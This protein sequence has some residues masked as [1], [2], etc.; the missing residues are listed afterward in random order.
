[1]PVLRLKSLY[2]FSSNL[3]SAMRGSSNWAI[4]VGKNVTA[5]AEYDTHVNFTI[6]AGHTNAAM[7]YNSDNLYKLVSEKFNFDYE[8]FPVSKDAQDDKIRIWIN[9]G[10]MPD[11]VTWRNFNY[12]EYVSYAQQGLIAPLPDGW[13][14]TYPNLYGM[15][16][17]SGIYDQMIVDGAIWPL[18]TY[19]ELVELESSIVRRQT[20]Y[21][22]TVQLN[23]A[24]KARDKAMGVI[25]NIITAHKTNTIEAKR[26]AALALDA[27]AVS[28][29]VKGNNG[30][31][32]VSVGEKKVA[33]GELNAAT[34]ISNLNMR[35]SYSIPY[36]AV[37]LIEENAEVV[38]NRAR[39]Q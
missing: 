11:S 10:T 37:S 30:V 33:E 22:S 4:A 14:E 31:Y 28:A 29:P 25:L 7:D 9:G 5:L 32:V 34:E 1:M 26:T 19:G 27:N 16:K 13:E 35:T 18:P 12:Q 23:D 36:Q 20:A 8:V 3:R 17:T 2:T 39:F 38:D 6:N 15:I 24:D 21:V